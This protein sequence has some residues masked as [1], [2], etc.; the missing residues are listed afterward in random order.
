MS[1]SPGFPTSNN[2]GWAE[3][4]KNQFYTC[5]TWSLIKKWAAKP[6]GN[7]SDNILKKMSDN[8]LKK[9]VSTTAQETDYKKITNDQVGR[10]EIN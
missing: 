4:L 2:W 9:K 5:R 1:I 6:I 8:T 7:K 10:I 3:I